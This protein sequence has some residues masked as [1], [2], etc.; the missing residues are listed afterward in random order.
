MK[1]SRQDN[2]ALEQTVWEN[3]GLE[4]VIENIILWRVD[5]SRTAQVTVFLTKKKQL[6]AYVEASAPLVLADVKKMISRMGLTA[7]M[8]LPPKGQPH[9]FDDIGKMKFL[10]VFPG[11]KAVS[12]SDVLFYKTLAPYN[13]ALVMIS[14]VKN[15]EIYQ[16]DAD[17]RSGWRLGAK[18]TYRRIRTS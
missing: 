8:Y 17:A 1:V 7:E 16:Y 2:V 9:Y 4:V 10:E 18:F 14:G 15:G 11:R 13:P 3:F 12:E 6:L 5:T